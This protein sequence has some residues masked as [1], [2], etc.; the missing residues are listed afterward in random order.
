MASATRDADHLG[1]FLDA[2]AVDVG[3]VD[4][5]GGHA[6]E[7]GERRR[8]F[9]EVRIRVAEIAGD[10]FGGFAQL[11]L[12]GVVYDKAKFLL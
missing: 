11:V 8:E 9:M 4:A 10:R 7:A 12:I 5:L 2:G 3:E 1:Q 6:L